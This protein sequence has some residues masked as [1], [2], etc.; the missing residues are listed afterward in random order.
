MRVLLG[1]AATIVVVLVGLNL[2]VNLKPAPKPMI[3]Q[4]LAQLLPGAPR[5]WT[6]Q[7]EPIADTPEELE[8]VEG[9]LHFDDAA[10]RVYDDGHTQVAVYIAYWLP[11][12]FSPAKVGAHSPD[13]CWVHNG[14][15]TVERNHDVESPLA[16]GVLKPMETGL[17]EKDGQRVHVIFWH[18]VGGIPMHYDLSGWNNGI[19]GRIQRLPTLLDDFSKFGLDQRKE[20]LVIRL[21]SSESFEELWAD[22]GFGQFMDHLSRSFG[23]YS[24]LPPAT[25]LPAA[26]KVVGAI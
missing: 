8:K 4:P 21:S 3:N 20:Q 15:N 11:G 17:F 5:G 10:Y 19:V 9:V 13:T 2:Y 26:A 24:K 25:D 14:W 22:P 23:L 18:L 1:L 6:A 7:D 12:R 16:G